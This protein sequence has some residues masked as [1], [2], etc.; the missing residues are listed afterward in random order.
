[1]SFRCL[2]HSTAATSAQISHALHGAPE[3][4]AG[5]DGI[6]EIG[7]KDSVYKRRIPVITMH[8]KFS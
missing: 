3:G 4:N 7:G 6:S 2:G 5:W 1:M 8:Q